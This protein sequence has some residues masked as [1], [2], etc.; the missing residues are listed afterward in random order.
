MNIV[1]EACDSMLVDGLIHPTLFEIETALA[2]YYFKNKNCDVV[3]LETGL[4]GRDD[5][6]NVIV[7]PLASVITSISMDH[8][9]Y[10]GDTISEIAKIKAGIIKEN[11]DTIIAQQD[12]VVEEILHATCVEKNNRVYLVQSVSEQECTYLSNKT[13]FSYQGRESLEIKLLGKQQVINACL[14]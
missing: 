6:T 11:S 2:F 5:A 12:K 3:V 4:G 7:N 9:D 13:I 10:L 1:K 8:M 14:K